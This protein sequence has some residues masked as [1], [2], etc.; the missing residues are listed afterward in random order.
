MC[1]A[2]SA[3]DTSRL[4]KPGTKRYSLL[5]QDEI[6]DFI[7]S[8]NAEKGRGGFSAAKKKYGIGHSTV[9]K[10]LRR[11]GISSTLELGKKERAKASQK[12]RERMAAIRRELA[13]LKAQHDKLKRGV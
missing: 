12:M 5:E 11:E 3:Q 1:N 10:W 8:V 4:H 7:A 9:K 6:L 2:L 13:D